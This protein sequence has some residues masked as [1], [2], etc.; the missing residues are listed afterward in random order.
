MYVRPMAMASEC[1]SGLCLR[2]P[3]SKPFAIR[4]CSYVTLSW[5][6][7]SRARSYVGFCRGRSRA[8]LAPTWGCVAG[9]REQS[10]LL[11][12]VWSW[13]F[14]SRARSYVGFC[15]GLSRAELAPTW[16]FVVGFREQSLLLRGVL[17][18]AFAS[19]A[20]SYVG[21]CRGL[22]RAG[23]AP[24]WG[25]FVGFRE[26]SSRGVMHNSLHAQIGPIIL[27]GLNA[28]VQTAAPPSPNPPRYPPPAETL[29]A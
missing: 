6:F 22:S 15:R 28:E 24:T 3:A 12:G 21:L 18:W 1:R 4:V 10:S 27:V 14:A 11:R 26:Q 7:A 19:R 17:S 29:P 9:F 8:E 23:L 2:K 16:G 13:A 5:A 25:F 20:R